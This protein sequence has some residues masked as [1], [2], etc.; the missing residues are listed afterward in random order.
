MAEFDEPFTSPPTK[1]YAAAAALGLHII[2]KIKIYGKNK[3]RRRKIIII[4]KKSRRRLTRANH[5]YYY[6]YYTAQQ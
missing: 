5:F 2:I 3:K 1:F 4:I 6:Y